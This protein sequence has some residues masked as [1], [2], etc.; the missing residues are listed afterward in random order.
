MERSM[1]IFRKPI[2]KVLGDPVKREIKR[3]QGVV[4]LINELEDEMSTL[5]DE[6]LREKTR[7]FRERLGIEGTDITHGQSFAAGLGEETEEMAM[8]RVEEQERDAARRQALDDLLPRGL[9]GGPRGIQA[10]LG[11]RHFDVQLIGG[12]VLHQGRIAEMKTGEGK[13]LV[14]TLALYLTRSRVV[15]RT[16]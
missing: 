13:T 5:T 11:M 3:Y 10:H 2:N 14:A 16:S 12:I 7:E 6:E 9:R 8:E 1:S 4:D 15:A